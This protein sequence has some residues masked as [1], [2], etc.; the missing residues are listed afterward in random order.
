[1]IH[2]GKAAQ[3][4]SEVAKLVAKLHKS[5]VAN[6]SIY[7]FKT[8]FG[9]GQS[10]GFGLIYDDKDALK[11][12]RILFFPLCSRIIHRQMQAWRGVLYSLRFYKNNTQKRLE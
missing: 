5:D 8:A 11:K 10:T 2:P 1:V 4:K 7:G 12:V 6:V 9:G 3:P